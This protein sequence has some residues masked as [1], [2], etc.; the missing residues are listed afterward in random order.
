MLSHD[1]RGCCVRF[2][3]EDTRCAGARWLRCALSPFGLAYGAA[4]R[5]RRAA[6]RKGILPSRDLAVPVISVGNLS[7]GGTGK[8]PM[9][10][11]VVRRLAQMGR[12]PAILSRGY[13]A[14][15]RAQGRPRNDEA[16]LFE[17]RLPGIPHY[18]DPNRVAS[19]SRALAE[20]AD[21]LV[22]DDGFQ[23]LRARRNLDLVLVDALKPLLGRRI[24]PA[25]DLREPLSALR[26]A[27]AIIL[28][29]TDLLDAATLA[30]RRAEIAALAPN[31]PIITAAHRAT[32]LLELRAEEAAHGSK[33]AA[34]CAPTVG[35]KTCGGALKHADSLNALAGKRVMLFC[36]IG[37][38]QGFLET[39][40]RLKAEVVA[41]Q[42]LPDHFH[43][44][45]PDLDRLAALLE[46]SGAE[47]AVTT[48]KDAVK[49]VAFM[50]AG[51]LKCGTAAL[52][53][54]RTGEG[55]CA[56]SSS[57][58]PRPSAAPG[59][60]SFNDPAPSLSPRAAALLNRTR[61]L[62]V[63][64]AILSGEETLDAMLKGA[65]A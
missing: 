29:R 53:C 26:R 33:G 56:T 15:E 49:L 31:I 10:E 30:E 27:D 17:R 59:Q 12:H 44:S 7:A 57:D 2:L 48:E 20:G 37:N 50:K 46:N 36:G 5:L 11:W 6:Y 42:S 35:D 47:W 60:G 61:F 54:S 63:E 18:A 1:S 64:M 16:L 4:M 52:G 45:A 65:V 21:C 40:R 32:T 3:R 13:G 39:V 14:H 8:T 41:S 9:V 19:A 62:R 38:P 34:C 23:H 28:T 51:L 43:Y 58:Q 55:G 25:G 24:I 22:L